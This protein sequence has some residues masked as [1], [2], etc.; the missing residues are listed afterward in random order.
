MRQLVILL[1]VICTIVSCHSPV[2]NLLDRAE[3]CMGSR[4]DSSLALLQSIRADELSS[5]RQKARHAL[6][7]SMALDKNYIDIADDSIISRAVEYY[8]HKGTSRELMNAW[9]YQGLVRKNAG[10]YTAAIVSL[11][12]AE[13][14]AIERKDYHL[15]GLIFRNKASI[16][17]STN[18]MEEAVVNFKKSVDAF[19]ASGDT[20][21][22]V[23]GKYSLAVSYQRSGEIDESLKQ[24]KELKL[25]N[26]NPSLQNRCALCYARN[27]VEKGDSLE[28]A[29]H[30]FKQVPDTFFQVL[31]YGLYAIA[32]YET[33]QKDSVQ[34]LL[35]RGYKKFINREMTASLQ[36]LHSIIAY[37]D[38]DYRLAYQL[39]D[40]AL[41]MQDSLTRVLLRQSLS[42][43]Q[44][45]YYRSQMLLQEGV[46]KR[47]RAGMISTIC[48][49]LLALCI[50]T[51]ISLQKKQMDDALVKEQMARLSLAR[52]KTLQANAQLIGSL[53][54]ERTARLHH[55]SEDYF[56][57][58]DKEKKEAAFIQFKQA[59]RE[60]R[61]DESFFNRIESDL[62]KYCNGIMDKLSMQVPKIK[63]ANR[64]LISLL[65][66][67][68][69]GEWIQVL[70]NKNSSA[71]VKTSRS[72][73]RNIIKAAHAE[74][75]NLFLEMLETRKPPRV[76]SNKVD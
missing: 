56:Q 21:Y 15:L 76:E 61:D 68:L 14:E 25:L 34:F 40:Q 7:T 42:S 12:M 28:I 53:V 41:H 71:S 74:D 5:T 49:T 57:E 65:F 18:N 62:N 2:E 29:I 50:F 55:L 45:D 64:K 72:R 24:L 38:H 37:K 59:L 48:I 26:L 33:G 54:T 63:G 10:D 9:Y 32:L 11:E 51:L 67:G 19:E 39:E 23:Y 52:D 17:D 35:D 46:V 8:E 3:V 60:I 4:P 1:L 58:E 16:L 75:E 69:P 73:F 47:Q 27:L 13:R 31:D 43:A 22:A 44:R 30:L 70:G 66:A 20:L 6:L 36:Y